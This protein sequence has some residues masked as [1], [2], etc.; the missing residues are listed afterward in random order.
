MSLPSKPQQIAA[1]AKFLDSDKT[2]GKSL[3]EVAKA[4]VEGFHE[5]LLKDLKKPAQP[6]RLGMLFK[7][8]DGKVRRVAWTDGVQVWLVTD[9]A[10]YGWLGPLSVDSWQYAEEYRPKRRAEVDGK[11]KLVEMPDEDID[12]AW[13]NPHWKVGDK[14][15][16]HQREHMYQVIATAPTCVL[17]ASMETGQLISDSNANLEKHYRRESKVDS[18]W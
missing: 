5:A 18:E 9:N 15:S 17:M 6:L 2:E 11:V 13:S 4:I 12:E 8:V 7:H 3:D 16:Q 10:S 14:V 1:V